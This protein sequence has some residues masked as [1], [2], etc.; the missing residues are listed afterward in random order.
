MII[1]KKKNAHTQK[2]VIEDIFLELED[3]LFKWNYPNHPSQSY[4]K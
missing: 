3:Q 1:G 4:Y 2:N